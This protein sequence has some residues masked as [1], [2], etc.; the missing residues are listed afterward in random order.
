VTSKGLDLGGRDVPLLAGEVHY[1]QHAPGDWP[2][3]LDAVAGLGLTCVSTYVPWGVHE[4]APGRLDLGELRP[5][6][7]LPRFLALAHERSLLVLAR[8]GPHI[9]A[10]L[11]WLGLPRRVLEDEDVM[12][13]SSRGNPVWLPIAPRPF[14]VPSYASERFLGE[15]DAWLAEVGRR[16]APF[17][18]P[19]GPVALVQLDNEAPLVFRDGP[20]DQDYH[21]TAVERFRQYTAELGRPVAEPPRKLEAASPR[22]LVAH[23]DWIAFR[24][25]VFATALRRFRATLERAG[26]DRVAFTHNL[27]QA[28]AVPPVAPSDFDAADLVGFDFYHRRSQLGLLRDRCLYA[29]GTTAL[30]FAAELGWGGPW[31]LPVRSVDDSETQ[32][33]ATLAYGA[34][35]LDIFMA[36]D[37]DRY[38]GAPLDRRGRRQLPAAPRAQR[39][40]ELFT[41]LPGSGPSFTDLC[42]RAPVAVVVPRSYPLLTRATW[43][44]SPACPPAVEALGLSAL[45][46][47]SEERF[48]FEEPV[49]IAWTEALARIAGALSRHGVGHVVVDGAVATSRLAELSPRVVVLLS[50][51]F[52]DRALWRDVLALVRAGADLVLGPRA[53]TLGEDMLPL[54]D[55]VEIEPGASL[56]IGSGRISLA[57][58]DT[59]EGARELA[60]DLATRPGFRG[61]LWPEDDDLDVA[62]LERDGEARVAGVVDLGGKRRTVALGSDGPVALVDLCTG[63]RVDP[64]RVEVEAHQ[65]RL[66]GLE[67]GS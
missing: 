11:T 47:A 33:R 45:L 49:Q 1:F 12:A 21:P 44:L 52:I 19:D 59:P 28:G 58:L 56:A 16:L 29:V 67:V 38:Y 66:L 27:A 54:D 53:S 31:N 64:R 25:H 61:P 2:A 36:A 7:D 20:F 41:Q 24:H 34:R 5:A 50:Y 3:L 37:R 26:L 60:A 39:L 55:R 8:P 9:N 46:G 14:P 23:L 22:D 40:I 6:L 51:E 30:P 15:V 62:L 65:V 35:G 13:R 63:A 10:E 42:R 48:G 18:W 17:Q 43:L 4:T 57:R 32:M